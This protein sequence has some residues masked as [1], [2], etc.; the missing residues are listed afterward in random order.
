[1]HDRIIEKCKRMLLSEILFMFL[2]GERYLKRNFV[3]SPTINKDLRKHAKCID[4]HRSELCD[5]RI[6]R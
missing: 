4:D 6:G 2:Y 5:C 1:M 3:P